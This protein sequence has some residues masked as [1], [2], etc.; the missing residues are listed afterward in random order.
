[1]KLCFASLRWL[2]HRPGI[3]RVASR[4][5]ANAPWVNARVGDGAFV[6][7]W[8]PAAI[9]MWIQFSPEPIWKHGPDTENARKALVSLFGDKQSG[10]L[11]Q[12]Y[13]F[14]EPTF[15]GSSE[16]YLRFDFPNEAELV[17][18]FA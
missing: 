5:P 8:I 17:K 11:Y 3:L 13:F 16:E 7:S 18:R 2:P 4:W 15:V 9:Y 1:M 10:A 6:C 12:A 14:S